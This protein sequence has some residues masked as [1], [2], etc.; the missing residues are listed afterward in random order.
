MRFTLIPF[1]FSLVYFLHSEPE[2]D[3]KVAMVKSKRRLAA[4]DDFFLLDSAI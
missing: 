3:A 2:V 4:E 1:S